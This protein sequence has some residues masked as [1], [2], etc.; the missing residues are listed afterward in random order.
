MMDPSRSAEPSRRPETILYKPE[1]DVPISAIEPNRQRQIQEPVAFLDSVYTKPTETG[2][3][4]NL[5]RP[6]AISAAPAPEYIQTSRPGI[7]NEREQFQKDF[8]ELRSISEHPFKIPSMTKTTG[9]AKIPPGPPTEGPANGV[10]A[11]ANAAGGASPLNDSLGSAYN[12]TGDLGVGGLAFGTQAGAGLGFNGQSVRFEETNRFPFA[13][14]SFGTVDSTTYRLSVKMQVG[15]YNMGS[16]GVLDNQFGSNTYSNVPPNAAGLLPYDVNTLYGSSMPDRGTGVSDFYKNYM[17]TCP[18][19]GKCEWS[20]TWNTFGDATKTPQ[21]K[22]GGTTTPGITTPAVAMPTIDW[23]PYLDLTGQ[24]TL[25]PPATMA[26]QYTYCTDP[27]ACG[28]DTVHLVQ[29]KDSPNHYY[30]TDPELPYNTLQSCPDGSVLVDNNSACVPF[31]G[32]IG[33]RSTTTPTTTAT[34][35]AKP[36]PTNSI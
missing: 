11:P 29:I 23:S 3:Y 21:P 28:P 6:W 13:D 34:A 35:T 10:L 32:Q 18:P 25:C 27:V 24:H 4:G 22:N 9:W 8:A 36:T 15:G 17:Q 33:A 16:V 31:H 1:Y 5:E 7:P 2:S 30:C 12:S 20:T 14:I 26:D 19:K